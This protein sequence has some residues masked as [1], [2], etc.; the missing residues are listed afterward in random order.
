MLDFALFSLLAKLEFREIIIKKLISQNVKF[1][2]IFE[3]ATWD[4]LSLILKQKVTQLFHK[5]SRKRFLNRT[6]FIMIFPN[7]VLSIGFHTSNEQD[8]SLFFDIFFGPPSCPLSLEMN[9]YMTRLGGVPIR[10][11]VPPMLAAYAMDS[12][13]IVLYTQDLICILWRT[14]LDMHEQNTCSNWPCNYTAE[15]QMNVYRN[16]FF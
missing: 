9:S 10:V 4:C 12:I 16:K 1:L 8:T 5:R 6:K 11:P 13:I 7:I 15:E 2:K 3:K 14:L